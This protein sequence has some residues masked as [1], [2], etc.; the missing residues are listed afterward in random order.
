VVVSGGLGKNSTNLTSVQF[1]DMQTGAWY[2][3]PNLRLILSHFYAAPATTNVLMR[4]K[5]IIL[6]IMYRKGRAGHAMLV[7]NGKLMV[8]SFLKLKFGRQIKEINR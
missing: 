7:H 6:C 4:H 3:L 5:Y 8:R 1:Y 2:T